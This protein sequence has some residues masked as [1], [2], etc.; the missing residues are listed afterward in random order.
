VLRDVQV[1]LY[2]VFGYLLPGLLALGAL[3]A[4]FW[5][6]VAPGYP[7]GAPNWPGP[8]W[9]AVIVAAYLVG[10]LLQA[11]ANI[12]LKMSRTQ[13]ADLA[14][15]VLAGVPVPRRAALVEAAGGDEPSWI[16][17][18]ADVMVLQR[19]NPAD[20]DLFVYREG[21]YR[22]MA[23]AFACAI[24]A[25]AI[26]W[27]RDGTSVVIRGVA[28]NV[29]SSAFVVLLVIF[30]IGLVLSVGRYRRFA[31]Y[32]VSAAIWGCVALMDSAVAPSTSA[33]R[34]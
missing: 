30:V 7:L 11:A 3:A 13:D 10:H 25:G 1:T 27:S 9:V 12:A 31:R 32:R 29:P 28:D 20:R 22:G 4:V 14:A 8:G 17:R 23:G 5:A 24:A 21:F 6:V 2:D 34:G 16:Y 18:F 33:E 15:D 26:R 19:G